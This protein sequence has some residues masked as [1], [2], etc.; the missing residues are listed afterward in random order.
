MSGIFCSP[1]HTTSPHHKS[2]TTT[3]HTL[4][5]HSNRSIPYNIIIHNTTTL[6]AESKDAQKIT[7]IIKV[8]YIK[9]YS[10]SLSSYMLFIYIQYQ[11][12]GS[13]L[14]WCLTQGSTI[15]I[16]RI[17]FLRRA[18]H[19]RKRNTQD[20]PSPL[21]Q[22]DFYVCEHQPNISAPILSYSM[23]NVNFKNQ[24]T[25]LTP[26]AFSHTHTNLPSTLLLELISIRNQHLPHI[27]P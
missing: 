6:Y 11:L 22:H 25:Q 7:V 1:H 12:H 21:N 4:P 24:K 5:L 13:Y 16:C 2:P 14:L 23:P 3:P 17:W 18:L 15:N 27:V 8:R 20:H 26:I 9:T 10:S 19:F